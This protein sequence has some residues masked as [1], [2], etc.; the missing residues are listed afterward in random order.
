M[1]L[2]KFIAAAVLP[3]IL[4]FGANVAVP[5]EPIPEESGFG[6]FVNLGGGL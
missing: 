6:G 3:S 5:L 1:K 4:L 2:G